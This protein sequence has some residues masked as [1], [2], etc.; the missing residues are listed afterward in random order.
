MEKLYGRDLKTY[1]HIYYKLTA[2]KQYLHF[3]SRHPSHSKRSIPYNLARRICM[4]VSNT[5]RSYRRRAELKSY[6]QSIAYPILLVEGGIKKATA[7]DRKTLLKV[8]GK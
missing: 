6:L 5:S 8:R 4:V 1:I 3:S 7:I 2:I